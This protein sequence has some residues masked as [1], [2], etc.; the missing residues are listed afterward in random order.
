MG[1][2]D[3]LIS[4]VPKPD[5][6]QR[7]HE[8]IMRKIAWMDGSFMP[9][10]PY[11][12]IMWFTGDR[13]PNPP[14]HTHTFDEIFGFLGGDPEHPEELNATVKFFIED[15]WYTF[16]KSVVFHVPAGMEHAPMVFENV[17]KP[18]IHFS[19]AGGPEA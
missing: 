2:H 19:G 11:F 1:K 12:E 16:T 14:T 6:P 8:A 18:F 9:N 3:H 15:E 17:K 5:N 7:G 13:D 4:F 10:A